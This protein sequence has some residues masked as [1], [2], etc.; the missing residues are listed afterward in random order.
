MTKSSTEYKE[1]GEKIKNGTIKRKRK[2]K[3]LFKKNN[4][5]AEKK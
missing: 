1:R 4:R 5:G 3:I 2:R